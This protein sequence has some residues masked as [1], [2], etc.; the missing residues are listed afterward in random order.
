M[1]PHGH[2][3]H[4]QAHAGRFEG[5]IALLFALFIFVL[6]APGAFAQH[7]T[8]PY[9]NSVG[10]LNP[11]Y[12]NEVKSAIATVTAGSTLANQMAVV[13]TYPTAVWMD[14][15]GAITGGAAAGGRMSLAQHISA[16]LAQQSASGS[17]Q[18]IVVELVIY[19]LPDRDCAALAR[20]G[21]A[22]R[23]RSV[24]PAAALPLYGGRNPAD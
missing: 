1:Y 23:R 5:R 20:S 4:K 18:P 7:V 17:G 22:G 3:F 6:I 13:A 24:S 10:Y 8:N 19:D 11:D 16:A 9:A 21:S 14:H 15:I 2:L 12:T